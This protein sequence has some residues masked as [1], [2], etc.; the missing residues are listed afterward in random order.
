MS[1]PSLA[2]IASLASACDAACA[3]VLRRTER[4]VG[5]GAAV[6][7]EQRRRLDHRGA[8]RAQA[9]ALH[10]EMEMDAVDEKLHR[11]AGIGT[12]PGARCTSPL[13]E[14]EDQLSLCATLMRR[15]VRAPTS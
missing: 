13:K 5:A 7:Q 2:N 11:L 8:L 9:R 15:R 4:V 3:E 6:Q 10:V 1:P 12:T 14:L